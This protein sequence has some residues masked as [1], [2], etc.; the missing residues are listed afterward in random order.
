MFVILSINTLKGSQNNSVKI[1]IMV[2]SPKI[3]GNYGVILNTKN[4]KKKWK[5]PTY[6]TIFFSNILP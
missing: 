4:N 2:P 6:P 1:L 3:F 5:I